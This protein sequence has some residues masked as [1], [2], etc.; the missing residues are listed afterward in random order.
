MKLKIF[1]IYNNNLGIAGNILY[2]LEILNYRKSNEL[3]FF[4]FKNVLYSNKINTWDKFFYQPFYEFNDLIEKKIKNKNF[5]IEHYKTN[6][7]FKFSYFNNNTKFFY[8]AELVEPLRKKFL[9]YIKF[10]NNIIDKYQTFKRKNLI[11]YALSVHLRGGDRF[12]IRPWNKMESFSSGT[13]LKC[14]KNYLKLLSN[15]KYEKYIEKIYQAKNLNKIFLATDDKLFYM[16]M[17]KKFNS[18]MLPNYSSMLNKYKISDFNDDQDIGV[19]QL[20]VYEDEETKT[21]LGEEAI[22]DSMIMSKCKYSILSKSSISLL[23]ILLKNDYNFS[24]IDG[25]INYTS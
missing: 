20:N 3:I 11:Q 22:I 5:E 9:K 17:K 2:A 18:L 14:P 19:H 13:S 12:Q 21:K 23:T 4:D 1:K 24:F 8:N 10:K 25:D 15:M 6:K 16:K 7:F